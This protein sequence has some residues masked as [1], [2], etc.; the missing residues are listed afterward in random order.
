MWLGET[1]FWEEQEQISTNKTKQNQ[2][3]DYIVS[4][5]KKK[6]HNKMT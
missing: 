6:P 2:H 5:H 4:G 1:L 3:N